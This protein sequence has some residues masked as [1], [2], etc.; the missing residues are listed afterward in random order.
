MSDTIENN[1]PQK[2]GG[3]LGYTIMGIVIAGLAGA[4]IWSLTRE[5]KTVENTVEVEKVVEK[6]KLVTVVDTVF[7]QE[8]KE[9][10]KNFNAAKFK[11]G[12]ADLSDDAKFVLYDLSKVMLENTDLR[13]K[14]V[15][16]TSDEG[17][18]DFNK[19]LSE[20]RAKAAVDFLISRGIEADRLQFEGKGSS[21]PLD[22]NN[23]EV[24]RRTEFIVL[25]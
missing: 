16:H 4:L 2:K 12:K 21:E 5:P 25:D 17:N 6:E 18:A 14:I 15:G 19:K 7:M 24:N 23:R 8:V 22:P 1:V 9:I 10:E 11:A 13:L 3:W 20:K